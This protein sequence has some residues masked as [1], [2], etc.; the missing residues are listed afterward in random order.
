MNQH[1]NTEKKSTEKESTEKES[2]PQWLTNFIKVYQQ[3]NKNNLNMLPNLYHPDI[4]FQDPVHHIHG[5]KKLTTYFELMYA[6]TTH[7]Q[8]QIDQVIFNGKR[9]AVYW[10]MKYRHPRLN[11]GNT[12]TVEGH[13]LV[14]GEE[15]L[16]RY[17]RDYLDMGAMVYEHAPILGRLVRFLKNRL[18]R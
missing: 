12:I 16:V 9:A 13:T 8:F 18:S 17:H 1:T 2:Y 7:C 5:L 3:L 4:H 10:T 6:Q 15:N 11:H 14:S